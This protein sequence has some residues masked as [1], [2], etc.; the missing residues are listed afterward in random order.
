MSAPGATKM[1]SL[2]KGLGKISRLGRAAIS[3]EALD[4][5][6]LVGDAVKAA[7]FQVQ[8]IQADITV[9]SLPQAVGDAV[10]IS[11]VFPTCWIMP[12]S[13]ATRIAR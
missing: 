1:D 6:Q 10:Q 4:M 5:N 13:T 2:L 12:S 8:S 11:Q 7:E 3:P 9:D